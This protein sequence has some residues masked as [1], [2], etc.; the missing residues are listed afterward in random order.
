MDDNVSVGQQPPTQSSFDGL[1]KYLVWLL[2]ILI[3][4]ACLLIAYYFIKSKDQISNSANNNTEKSV[5][6]ENTAQTN[7][8]EIHSLFESQYRGL[9]T[10]INLKTD[11]G[12]V[13]IT[14]QNLIKNAPDDTAIFEYDPALLSR[15]GLAETVAQ[16]K[17]G[18]K[19]NITQWTDLTSEKDDGLVALALTS[20][21]N[22]QARNRAEFEYIKKQIPTGQT[23]YERTTMGIIKNI[24]RSTDGKTFILTIRRDA[25]DMVPSVDTFAYS[26]N[27][28][29][30]STLIDKGAKK[31]RAFSL[32]KIGDKVT[33]FETNDYTKNYE[34]SIV[35]LVFSKL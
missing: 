5:P 18:D 8:S 20:I 27:I 9:I 21:P 16:L 14:L 15:F 32:L 26:G 7:P 30:T 13:Q 2:G 23:I 3:L 4:V 31:Q 11:T 25:P 12:K 6:S 24:S 29:N 19:L 34:N 33:L 28:V 1:V 17:V 35:S 22:L 10:A